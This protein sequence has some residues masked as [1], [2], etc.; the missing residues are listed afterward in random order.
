MADSRRQF[1][2]GDQLISEDRIVVI[3]WIGIPNGLA[4]FSRYL[5]Q[6][7]KAANRQTREVDGFDA[8]PETLQGA[9]DGID[10]Q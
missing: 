10:A 3:R 4:D 2:T 6:V 5:V 8:F 9:P 7:V 1:A